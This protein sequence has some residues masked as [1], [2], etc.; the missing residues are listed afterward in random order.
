MNG[1]LGKAYLKDY[2][3]KKQP[4]L[5][6]Y[7]TS[8]LPEARQISPLNEEILNRFLEMAKLGK[9][10]RGSL[11][12]L[13]Y[14]LSGGK[15]LDLILDTSIFVELFHTAVLIHDDFMDEDDTRRGLPTMHKQFE[16]YGKKLAK[17]EPTHYGDS[18]SVGIGDMGLFMAFEK[19]ATAN[20]PREILLKAAHIYNQVIIRVAYGQVMDIT[21]E[22]IQQKSEADILNV[23]RY[24][25]SEYTG[26]MPLL[27]GATLAGE[28]NAAK[29]EAMH[30]YGDSFGWAFQIQDDTLGLYSKEEELGKPI[31]SDLREGKNTLF[32]LH[33]SKHGTA[34]QKEFQNRIMGNK[35]ITELDVTKMQQILK[36]SGSYD[37][38]IDLGWKYVEEGKKYIPQITKDKEQQDILE[39]LLVYMMERTK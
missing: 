34:E 26:S 31:G 4:L 1:E 19:L 6:K 33:L 39:S 22:N 16:E 8:K 10:I 5:E 35:H 38:V 2:I 13:G 18:M 11:I 23:L 27:V 32:M 7:I 30:K 28:T 14:K 9:G 15:D 24:K 37:H 20:F 36:D 25:T 29:L 12:V 3:V 21:N 17:V